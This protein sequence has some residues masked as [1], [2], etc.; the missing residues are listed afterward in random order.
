MGERKTRELRELLG[1]AGVAGGVDADA[2]VTGIAFDSREVEPGD[3]FVA[4]RG[5][6]A[7]GHA[8]AAQAAQ[9]GAVAVLAEE[10]VGD[11]AVPVVVV[12]DT[13]AAL[14]AL[15][16]EW[17]GRPADRLR[18]IGVTGTVGKTTVVKMLEAI[19]TAA[20]RAPGVS[21]S[22][23]AGIGSDVVDT[24]MTTPD[25]MTLHAALAR[26]AER[27]D[28]VLLEVTSHSLGQGRVQG[29]E[30]DLGVFTNL[31]MLEH[32]EYHDSFEDYVRTK[33]G[34]FDHVPSGAPVVFPAGD[35]LVTNAVLEHDVTPVSCGSGIDVA[36]H[37]ERTAMTSRGTRLLVQI[38]NPL[39]RLDGGQVHA[40]TF[41]IAIQ[42]L[43]RAAVNNA[44]L[45][46]A[47]AL[48][49]GVPPE[50]IAK[51]LSELEPPR[52]RVQLLHVGDLC[53]LDDTVGHPDSVTGVFE[54]AEVVPHDRL[55][56]AYAVRGGRGA[57]INRR[58]AEA[59]GIW[60]ERVPLAH[61]AVTASAERTDAA[62]QVTP[63]ERDAFVAALEDA[64]VPYA[65]HERL[66]DGVADVYARVRSG[67]LLMLLGA[68]GMDAGLEVLASQAGEDPVPGP[69]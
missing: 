16:A 13:R 24:G 48:V 54:V 66:E 51:A 64:G 36:A 52:R 10:G 35:R 18:V 32:L 6:R 25:P 39:P 28:T 5:R 60:H 30:F 3:L 68:Q 45:A 27:A 67:D 40:Q 69:C 20:G 56:A 57:E 49:V 44:S 31:V 23:G 14:A 34:F 9:A 1:A 38:E 47:A 63:E 7:D 33:L 43:G 26:I 46:T 19:L 22:L 17:H 12:E 55:I 29:I 41:P 8:F 59:I 11:V 21:G 50:T 2:S 4:I 61:L 58:D 53:V 42:L 15:A 62:N 65:Y 37:V